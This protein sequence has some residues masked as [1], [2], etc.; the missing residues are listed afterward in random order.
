MRSSRSYLRVQIVLQTLWPSHG[1]HHA[2]QHRLMSTQ[3]SSL[4]WLPSLNLLVAPCLAAAFGIQRRQAASLEINRGVAA[5]DPDD[6]SN[7]PIRKRFVGLVRDGE[8]ANHVIAHCKNDR[9]FE[10]QKDTASTD[11]YGG[12]AHSSAVLVHRDGRSGF[13]RKALFSSPL[14]FHDASLLFEY[15]FS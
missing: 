11:I 6:A 3:E 13:N 9:L 4:G 12:R 2:R 14:R 1:A 8:V 10:L 15:A 5:V 7:P